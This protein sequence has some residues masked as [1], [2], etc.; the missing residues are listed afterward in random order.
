MKPRIAI[1]FL[2]MWAVIICQAAVITATVTSKTAADV[3]GDE[4]GEVE[5][6]YSTTGTSKDRLTSGT[7]ATMTL[8]NLPDGTIE[9]VVLYMHSNTNA[10]AGSMSLKLNGVAIATV[11]DKK[12]S[13]WPGIV[14]FSTEYKQVGFS[15]EWSMSEGSTLTLQIQ[16]SENSLYFSKMEVAYTKGDPK[17]HTVTLNWNTA[18]GDKQTTITETSLGSG[19]VLPECALSSFSLEGEDWAFA[20]WAS[21]CVLA[22]MKAAPE[23]LYVGDTYYPT[24]NTPLYAVYKTVPEEVAIMQ[25]TLFQ[26]GDYALVM[27][28]AEDLYFIASGA[29]QDKKIKATQCEVEMQADGRYRLL[30]DY[31]PANARY[32]VTFTGQTLQITNNDTTHS[33]IGHTKTDLTTNSEVWNWQKGKNHSVAIYFSPVVNNEQL[34]GKLLMPFR[35]S[36]QEAFTFQVYSMAVAEENEYALLFD[37]TNVPTASETVWTT[38]PFGYNAF[39]AITIEHS[40]NKLIRNG[41]IFIENNGSL[42]DLVGRKIEN[43]KE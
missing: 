33:A 11:S 30:Q 8:T 26:S 38:H 14:A 6:T 19:I 1:L 40:A 23:M 13:D 39:K 4:T 2:S 36:L 17:P 9:Y 22:R 31:V 15:G 12:F 24:H 35:Q 25:D 28:G 18:D 5:A 34:S 41:I 32:E 20:G 10:G 29:V 27:Q 43:R 42:Y 16:A 7:T 37:V 3:T 21:E